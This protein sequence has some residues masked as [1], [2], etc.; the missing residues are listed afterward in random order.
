MKTYLIYTP[1]LEEHILTI[2]KH[3]DLEKIYNPPMVRPD[4]M[5]FWRPGQKLTSISPL[6]K[7]ENELFIIG[8]GEEGKYT[9]KLMSM[10]I[11]YMTDVAQEEDGIKL[12]DYTVDQMLNYFNTYVDYIIKL[13]MEYNENLLS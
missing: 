12:N 2:I 5:P 9:I 7:T 13:G 11:D 4:E 8:S 10:F 3:E 6:N 1:S